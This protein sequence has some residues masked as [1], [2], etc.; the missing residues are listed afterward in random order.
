M[1]K[2]APHG[3]VQIEIEGRLV[4]LYVEGPWNKELVVQTHEQLRTELLHI[5]SGSWALMVISLKS[6]LTQP[7]ALEQIRATATNEVAHTG[8]IAT[9]W[10][11]GKGIEGGALMTGVLREIYLGVNEFEVFD[12]EDDAKK[13]LDAALCASSIISSAVAR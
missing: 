8:R 9:A 1:S 2:F 11:M 12:T 3:R 7:E 13:W 10:V 6:A 4:R 5:A